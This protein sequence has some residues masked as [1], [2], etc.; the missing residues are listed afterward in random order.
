MFQN[1]ISKFVSSAR[2]AQMAQKVVSKKQRGYSMIEIAIGTVIVGL[3]L[4][5]TISYV[6]GIIADNR[7]NDELKE[8][9]L[10]MSKLT[11]MYSNRP[12]FNGVTTAVAAQNNVYPPE[13]INAGGVTLNNRFGGA[14]TVAAGTTL[15]A[16]DS[17]VLTYT[18]VGASECKTM[19]PQ[20]EKSMTQITVGGTVVMPIGGNVNFATLGTSCADNVTVLY[21][22]KKS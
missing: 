17:V 18:G 5:V 20:L 13:R 2:R 19:V 16:D 14:I 9:P 8:I 3:L 7:A 22:F 1:K 15:Q 11:K 12:N 10:V 4:A 6:R 21:Q